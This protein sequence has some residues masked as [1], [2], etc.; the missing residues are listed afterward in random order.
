MMRKMLNFNYDQIST[1]TKEM[2]ND[3]LDYQKKSIQELVEKQ[4]HEM[5]QLMEVQKNETAYLRDIIVA[6]GRKQE[7]L[8]KKLD[9]DLD[10]D[11]SDS[12]SSLGSRPKS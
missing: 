4:H 3:I 10:S 6:M 1:Q 7:Q 2:R 12:D 9:I 5:E 11:V 8:I